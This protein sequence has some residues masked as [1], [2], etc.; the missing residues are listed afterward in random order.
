M[1]KWNLGSVDG[2]RME[3]WVSACA[4]NGTLGQCMCIEWNLGSV[5]VHRVEPGVSGCA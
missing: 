5:H 2:R 1:H 3:P 4:Q